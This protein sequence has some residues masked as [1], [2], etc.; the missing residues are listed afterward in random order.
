MAGRQ[1]QTV[2]K[3][4]RGFRTC[5]ARPQSHSRLLRCSA[6]RGYHVRR[7]RDGHTTYHTTMVGACAA[8]MLAE[9][10][11]AVRAARRCANRRITV[12]PRWTVNVVAE[13]IG[14]AVMGC[15]LGSRRAAHKTRLQTR[16]W[17]WQ[18]QRSGG[19]SLL[20]ASLPIRPHGLPVCHLVAPLLHPSLIHLVAAA[21]ECVSIRQSVDR[22]RRPRRIAVVLRHGRRWTDV[23]RKRSSANRQGGDGGGD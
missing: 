10:V 21:H 17:Q 20:R 6:W 14:I 23:L 4:G 12:A 7:L 9:R 22:R 3:K 8:A 2:V 18:A 15:Q 5:G 19:V 11:R 13:F 1:L 16:R